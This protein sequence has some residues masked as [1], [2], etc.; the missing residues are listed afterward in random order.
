MHTAQH[1]LASMWLDKELPPLDVAKVD[2]V[3]G[4]DKPPKPD[5]SQSSIQVESPD[6]VTKG[7]H[8]PGKFRLGDL[9]A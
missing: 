1:T 7:D 8:F 6:D 9:Y 4:E 3:R 5:F 2:M